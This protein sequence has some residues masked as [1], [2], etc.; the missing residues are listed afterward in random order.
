MDM[1][2]KE[3]TTMKRGL[4]IG[5]IL[6]FLF[7]V[8]LAGAHSLWL[9]VDGRCSGVGQ[10]VA[11]DIGWGHKFPKDTE[12]KEGM[13][14][15]VVAIDAEGKRIPLKQTSK[16]AFEFVPQAEGVYLICASVHP[17]FVSKTTEGYKMGPKPGFKQVISCFHYN[18]RTK[19]FV[20]AGHRREM[21]LQGSGDPLE[22]IP[23]KSPFDLKRGSDLPVKILF[24]GT[25]LAGAKVCATYAGYSDKPSVFAQTIGTD[26]EGIARIGVT[27]KGEWMV[28]V[29][30]EIPYPD[31]KECD[32]NKY[33]ATM[34]F[35][36][37]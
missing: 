5:T 8:P 35:G 21:P 29:T 2:G 3:K 16:T 31:T 25:P 11:V 20:C 33:N 17:G 18:I 4:Q 34:T 37:Q 9:N 27:Q 6:F 13:L 14:K 15:E 10:A 1:Q 22:I 28:S 24:N 36:V 23:L 19:A 12:I 7:W 32:T 30:H 26:K